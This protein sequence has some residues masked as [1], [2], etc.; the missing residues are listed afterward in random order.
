MKSL[1]AYTVKPRLFALLALGFVLATIVGTV[2]HEASH[3][4]AAKHYGSKPE[5]HYA[6][7]SFKTNPEKQQLKDY[8]EANHKKIASPETTA[9]KT[10]FRKNLKIYYQKYFYIILAGPAQTMLTGIIGIFLLWYWTKRSS[11]FN[12]KHWLA[13]FLAFFWSRQ[14]LNFLMSIPNFWQQYPSIRSDESKLSAY[15]RL[16]Y[17]TIGAITA[18]IGL[19]LLLWVVFYKMPKEY[20]PSF[21]IAGVVGSTLGWTLWMHILGPVILP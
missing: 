19:I 13:V 18:V 2:S 6:M 5:L 15:L 1:L 7:V 10:Y 8:Y 3:Y 4:F 20:R 17:W 12:I 14:V 11:N 9:E 16:P 21:I